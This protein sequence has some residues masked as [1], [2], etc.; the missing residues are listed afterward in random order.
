MTCFASFLDT[1][2]TTRRTRRTTGEIT[3]TAS[4]AVWLVEF[5]ICAVH[6]GSIPSGISGIGSFNVTRCRCSNDGR[7]R[8]AAS[9]EKGSS[10]ESHP[11]LVRGTEPARCGFGVRRILTTAIAWVNAF[12]Q[13]PR[14]CSKTNFLKNHKGLA[15]TNDGEMKRSSNNRDVVGGECAGVGVIT[16]SVGAALSSCFGSSF[17]W[18]SASPANFQSAGIAAK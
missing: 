6:G 10:M 12:L 5:W 8:D 4:F 18:P 15:A 17:S 7:S 14:N 2:R 1:T 16:Q 13:R 11:C 3:S 9:V